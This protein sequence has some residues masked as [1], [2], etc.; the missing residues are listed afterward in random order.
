MNY[1]NFDEA[2]G[3][4]YISPKTEAIWASAQNKSFQIYPQTIG[5]GVY[6]DQVVLDGV[7]Q[8]LSEEGKGLDLTQEEFEDS[9]KKTVEV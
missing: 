9:D 8:N 4:A 2:S 6:Y 1:L 7:E 5:Q 3:N